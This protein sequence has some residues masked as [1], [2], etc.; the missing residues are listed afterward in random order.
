MTYLC[1]FYQR[2]R[3]IEIPQN[4]DFFQ[5]NG[6]SHEN[7]KQL[8]RSSKNRLSQKEKFFSFFS[9]LVQEFHLSSSVKDHLIVQIWNDQYQDYIDIESF[10]KIPSE[11]RLQVFV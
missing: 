7:L 11:G 10:K 8:I 6:I 5:Q 2:N 1:R 3:L 4:N 9:D